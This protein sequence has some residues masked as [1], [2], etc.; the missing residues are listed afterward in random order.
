MNQPVQR[1]RDPLLATAG[2]PD[3]TIVDGPCGCHGD[4]VIQYCEVFTQDLR[5]ALVGI[6]QLLVC[7]S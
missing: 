7:L 2:A 3:A 6:V 5:P 4:V 1:R